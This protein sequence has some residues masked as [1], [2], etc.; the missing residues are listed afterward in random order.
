MQGRNRRRR[1]VLHIKCTPSFAYQHDMHNAAPLTTSSFGAYFAQIYGCTGRRLFCAF[2]MLQFKNT[3]FFLRH[4]F[5]LIITAFCREWLA[6]TFV[7][8]ISM[9]WDV[10][11]TRYRYCYETRHR[12]LKRTVCKQRGAGTLFPASAFAN[13]LRCRHLFCKLKI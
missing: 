10:K 9:Q 12:F 5:L 13:E 2:L 6:G 3:T 1:L 4:R 8:N 11:K 7:Y